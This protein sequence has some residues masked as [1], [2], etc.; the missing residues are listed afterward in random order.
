MPGVAGTSGRR[1]VSRMAGKSLNL[2]AIRA[3]DEAQVPPRLGLRI[4]AV[5]LVLE[6]LLLLALSLIFPLSAAA[7]PVKAEVSVSTSAGFARF[8]FRFADETEADIRLNNGIMVIAFKRPVD[9]SVDRLTVGAPD[10]VNAARRDP[11]GMAVRVAL[12]RKVTANSMA[13][14]E[15]L[16]VDLLPEG[17]VGLPPSLPQEVVDDL[18]RRAREAEKKERQRRQL[19]QQS[20]QPLIRLCVGTQ[21]TF[22][23][24]VFELPELT[25]VTI[26]RAKDRLTVLFDAPLRFDLA[27]A[28]AAL[29]PSVAA[30]EARPGEDN[31]SVRFEFAD[32]PD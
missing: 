10:Y 18:A 16:F 4:L 32:G 24:Y 13:A 11:D 19:A 17:W 8:V 5:F 26:D 25:P 3:H 9:V 21:P 1:E 31:T 27:E 7:A 12:G 23:R 6:A 14:G 15:R 2:R 30:I 28:Q 29:P 22:T 20:Q